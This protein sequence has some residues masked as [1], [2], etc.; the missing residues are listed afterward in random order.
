M[1]LTKQNITK[2]KQNNIA[3]HF[4]KEL[5]VYFKPSAYGDFGFDIGIKNRPGRNRHQ[6]CKIRNTVLLITT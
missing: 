5:L 4:F 2:Q 1:A 6:M 3:V